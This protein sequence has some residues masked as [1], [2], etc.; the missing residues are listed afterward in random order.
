MLIVADL[1]IAASISYGWENLLAERFGTDGIRGVAN[2]VLTGDFVFKL[3]L[4]MAELMHQDGISGEVFIGK[5]TRLSSDM[6]EHAMAS[7][8]MSRGFDVISMG[9]VPTAGMAHATKAHGGILGVMISASHNQIID[10]GVKFFNARG[11]KLDEE[12]ERRI[13]KAFDE[14]L[15]AG[16][17]LSPTE[18]GSYKVPDELHRNYIEHL[19]SIPTSDLSGMKI[20]LDTAHGAACGYAA[21]VFSALGAEIETLHDEPDG[22]RI[23]V[24]CGSNYPDIVC[25]KM[26]NQDAHLGVAF[27]GDADRAILIDENGKLVN[28]DQV[29]AMWGL[30]K[31]A[32]N[33]LRNNTIV[34]T[35]LSNQGLEVVLQ[36]NGGKL[37]RTDV[38]D[39]YI[40]RKMVEDDYEI[41]GEQSGHIIFLDH[42]LT[43][44]GITTALKVAE[45]MRITNEPLS[46][47]ADKFTPY[48]QV[49]LN[50]PT[51]DRTSW[52]SDD[53]LK[54]I[55]EN[56]EQE[57]REKANGRLLIRASG[58]QPLIRIMVEAEDS[59]VANSVAERMRDSFREYCK[60]NGTLILPKR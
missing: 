45:L 24:D 51:T 46:K 49:A 4:T 36:E 35:V 43:G 31:L 52:K 26:K 5:D 48:P 23:N 33:N 1:I 44:D 41:G 15:F 16:L 57:V 56:L 11:M 42:F 8:F 20:I 38:G 22:S 50:V 19:K 7:G 30:H 28:G 9:V 58:T 12:E 21:E 54:E 32:N 10:N 60:K 27:D 17:D 3:A 18:L 39:K 6:L 40:M 37:I 59:D 14:Q 25:E 53:T 13:E 55:A 29:L 34:G 47:L 2:D